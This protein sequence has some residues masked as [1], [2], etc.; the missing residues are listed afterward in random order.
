M[1]SLAAAAATAAIILASSAIAQQTPWNPINNGLNT[2]L[3]GG[4]QRRHRLTMHRKLTRIE[5]PSERDQLE[6]KDN[7][8]ERE[9]MS[10]ETKKEKKQS[11]AASLTKK[12]KKPQNEVNKTTPQKKDKKVQDSAAKSFG[13]KKDKK[14][15]S[16]ST[17]TKKD[18]KK[19]GSTQLDDES[20]EKK[21][22]PSDSHDDKSNLTKQEKKQS[23]NNVPDKSKKEKKG[24]NNDEK[25]QGDGHSESTSSKKDKKENVKPWSEMTKE[26]KKNAM[27]QSEGYG[28]H[29]WHGD[30]EDEICICED[31]YDH[32]DRYLLE[33]HMELFDDLE[34]DGSIQSTNTIDLT[35]GRSLKLSDIFAKHPSSN[36]K[37]DELT[38]FAGL[39]LEQHG[40][41]SGKSGD[42]KEGETWGKR[43]IRTANGQTN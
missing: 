7:L 4:G 16:T 31:D 43:Q 21:Q 32:R 37:R 39:A 6:E 2:Q 11:N 42:T 38:I 27:K 33:E 5:K 25:K 22:K 26:H 18:E 13:N 36:E 30:G 3:F 14:E 12:E 35:V 24:T 41:K 29:G 17:R 23:G 9:L 10:G 15:I 1:S 34:E 8:L 19:Q 40:S 20:N 28:D